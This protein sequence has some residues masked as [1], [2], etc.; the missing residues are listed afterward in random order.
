MDKYLLDSTI[1]I[2]ELPYLERKTK[3]AET[4]QLVDP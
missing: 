1:A 4:Q 2:R 3:A